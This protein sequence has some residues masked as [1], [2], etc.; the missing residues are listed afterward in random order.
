VFTAFSIK[1]VS[2]ND[3]CS[4]KSREKSC[5]GL[6]SKIKEQNMKENP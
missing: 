3:V 6:Y 4:V 1:V 5:G 2:G